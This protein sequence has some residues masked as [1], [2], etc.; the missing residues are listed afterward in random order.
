MVA[1]DIGVRN[2]HSGSKIKFF[3]IAPVSRVANNTL[4]YSVSYEWLN[5]EPSTWQETRP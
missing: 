2:S 5:W 4:C 1:I 3:M